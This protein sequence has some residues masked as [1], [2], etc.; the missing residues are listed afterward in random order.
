MVTVVI[1]SAGAPQSLLRT[2]DSVAA[3]RFPAW[4]IAVVDHGPI[5]VEPLLRA[6]PVWDRISY[7]RLPTPR[8][9]AAARNLG[10]RMARG[11]YLAFLDPDERFDP[12][13]LEGMMAVIA[14]D[15]AEVAVATTRLVLERT[16]ASA[17]MCEAIGALTP[18]GGTEADVASLD[19]SHAVPLSALVIYRGALD[20]VGAFNESLSLLEDWELM[21]RLSRGTRFAASPATSVELSARLGLVAQRLGAGL[22]QYLVMLDGVYAAHAVDEGRAERR[23]RHRE[24]VARALG[25]APDWIG[26]PRGLAAL[27]CT[28]AGRSVVLAATA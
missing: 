6:H 27:L 3:Q 23:R 8:T 4:E 25:A 26:E 28:L 9:A 12:A 14:R 10:L 13:H 19:V 11:E 1:Q 22:S 24:D 20:R 5:P 16:N 7:V 15:E 21:L 18:F 17:S 2:I